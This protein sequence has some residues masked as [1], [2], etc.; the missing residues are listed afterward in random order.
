MAEAQAEA[1]VFASASSIDRL[2]AL[3]TDAQ[4]KGEN[5]SDN[6]ELSVRRS[7]AAA[8]EL[9]RAGPLPIVPGAATAYPQAHREVLEQAEC[10]RPLV[11]SR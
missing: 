8:Q 6:E 10:V 9:T 3:M 4:A 1:N 2:L 5:V 11:G 7:L